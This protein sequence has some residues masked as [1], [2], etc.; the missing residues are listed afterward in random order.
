[1]TRT[2]TKKA[3]ALSAL[4]VGALQKVADGDNGNGDGTPLR[5]HRIDAATR[6]LFA[7]RG[8]IPAD[9]VP[10]NATVVLT[11]A[12]REALQR[13]LAEPP[14]LTKALADVL[15]EIA[16]AGDTGL[17][18]W[19][20]G[21]TA[22][23]AAAAAF[24]LVTGLDGQPPDWGEM[25]GY[26]VTDA[27]RD[28]L[29]AWRASRTPTSPTAAQARLLA[30][31]VG[32][33][34]HTITFQELHATG[35]YR[36]CERNS[37]IRYE[38]AG[39]GSA[40][41][42]CHI[43]D[44]GREALKQYLSRVKHPAVQDIPAPPAPRRVTAKKLADVPAGTRVRVVNTRLYPAA[45]PQWQVLHRVRTVPRRGNM[46]GGVLVIVTGPDGPVTYPTRAPLHHQTQF[47]I[48]G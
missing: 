2:D 14:A 40:R 31:L 17:R 37:W 41:R 8:W 23:F 7:S 15:S 24:S 6:R 21:D 43:T 32:V 20:P 35:T 3:G 26:R 16:A 44:E 36:S 33:G 38:P 25:R 34:G 46:P 12:G 11:D 30:E 47:E 29:T 27:G 5:S 1:M 42:R 39:D 22:T 28:A 18:G 10:F 9:A 48:Q 45:G 13:G 4:Q 19:W